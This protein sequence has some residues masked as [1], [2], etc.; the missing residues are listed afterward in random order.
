MPHASLEP[1]NPE[2]ILED[3][4][5]SWKGCPLN[6]VILRHEICILVTKNYQ[7]QFQFSLFHLH[8]RIYPRFI[9][10]LGHRHQQVGVGWEGP[11]S[12]VLPEKIVIQRRKNW[13]FH[14]KAFNMCMY[15]Y[16]QY[17][18]KVITI[19]VLSLVCCVY[20]YIYNIHSQSYD[21]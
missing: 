11:K 12:T 10:D 4:F 20:M 21:C 9:S 13:L 16:I 7:T 6:L 17:I 5:L 3:S 15:V 18:V 8:T 1:E 14:K 19:S 2:D